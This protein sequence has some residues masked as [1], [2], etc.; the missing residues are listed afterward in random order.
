MPETLRY[1]KSRTIRLLSECRHLPYA[2]TL[3]WTA[4]GKWTLFW[5][6]LLLTQGI[7]PVALVYLTRALVNAAIA[8][9]RAGASWTALQPALRP[10]IVMGVLLLLLEALRGLTTYVR[11]LQA[12]LLKDHLS[13]L[14]HRAAGS[15][16][17][18]F[19]ESPAFY[20]R[21]HR[22]ML[23][24][25]SRPVL[26]IEALG[27]LLQNGVTLAAMGVVLLRFG[28]WL[29]LALLLCT[30]PALYV[31]LNSS[32]RRHEFLQRV[33]TAERQT[34]YYQWL[35][36]SGEAAAEVRLFGLAAH[37]DEAFQ[38]LRRHIRGEKLKLV[39]GQ[40]AGELWAAALALLITAGAMGWMTWRALR[41]FIT[42]GDLALFYQAFSHGSGL[43]R[44]LL[45][46]IGQL[47]ENG[48]FLGV[49]R[50]L[51]ELKPRVT[52]GTAVAV[53]DLRDGI[54]FANVSFRY[55]NSAAC[56]L[57]N[58]D[59]TIRP[60]ELV[61]LVGPNG[62]GKSTVIKL[63]TRLYEPEAGT[64][65]YDGVPL[66]EF[67][68]EE[69][70]TRI[71]VLC[72]DAV[73]FNATAAENIGYGDLQVTE[74]ETIE[75]AALRAGADTIVARLPRGLHTLLG[76]AYHDGVDLSAGEWQRIALGRA[77]LRDV[78]I[79]V[80]DEPT[81]AMDPWTEQEWLPRLRDLARGR[82]VLLITQRFTTA[83]A[84]DRIHVLADGHIVESGSHSELL[85]RG[86]VYAR[87]WALE[88]Q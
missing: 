32:L 44:S 22:A 51:L 72:Q 55:P 33:T 80:L 17:F 65:R 38:R 83:M 45:G 25:D 84:A 48:L 14:V 7:L 2:L 35:L 70:R 87:G 37:F 30:L 46:S 60:N 62:A 20:D 69:L 42:L 5:L 59:L 53:P 78:P 71:S 3:L 24:A 47:Y 49:L 19:Y 9:V 76:R 81:S 88:E 8:G 74:P 13:S 86:G 15:A 58:F 18:S 10:A 12:E 11:T 66:S 64:I 23:E 29:P 36:T 61:A 21:L 39:R 63:L 4:A 50:E 34:W 6:A 52:T 1:T 40:V 16:E 56:V 79:L 43:T 77:L 28:P 57:R 73:R 82:A 75:K 68:P 31:V 67:S 85:A 27:S 26:L 54:S 41:G